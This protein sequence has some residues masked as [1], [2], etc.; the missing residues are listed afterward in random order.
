MIHYRAATPADV[1]ALRA[2][3]QALADHDGGTYAVASEASLLHHGFGSRPLFSVVMAETVT[4]LGMVIFYPDY[5][6][7]RGEP[8]V[9]VQDI[10]VSDAARGMGVGRGLLAEMM[11]QQ[12][13]GAQFIAL[14]VSSD[15]GLATGFYARMGFRKRGYEAM[16]L[17]GEGLMAL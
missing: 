15:N 2:M 4:A 5:S 12:D 11:R 3:L 16:I 9:Y 6:T 13:W 14:G 10:Y 1:P 17:D 7:H 8:G